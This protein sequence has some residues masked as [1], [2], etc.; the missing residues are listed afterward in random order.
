MEAWRPAPSTTTRR[1]ST[2]LTE[3]FSNERDVSKKDEAGR[4]LIRAIFGKN[5]IADGP[6]R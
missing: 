4:N 1:I 2:P 6:A 3:H 5:A